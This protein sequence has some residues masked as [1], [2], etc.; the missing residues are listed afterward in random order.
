MALKN[1]SFFI[2]NPL[3][4]VTNIT[5]G[6]TVYSADSVNE[7]VAENP[8]IFALVQNPNGQTDLSLQI[9]DTMHYITGSFVEYGTG[10]SYEITTND[11]VGGQ[12]KTRCPQCP[13]K[14]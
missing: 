4:A 6:A 3:D 12:P 11:Y 1:V 14:P 2:G 5:I 8:T 10:V 9:D 7:L 13:P